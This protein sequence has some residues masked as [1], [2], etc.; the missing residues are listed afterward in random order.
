M[1]SKSIA[2]THDYRP[3]CG[4]FEIKN[5][6]IEGLG[7]FVAEGVTIPIGDVIDNHNVWRNKGGV[8]GDVTFASPVNTHVEMESDWN[9]VMFR[10]PVGGFINHSNS[11]SCAISK[12]ETGEGFN[13]Y[14]LVALRDLKAGE[15]VTVCYEQVKICSR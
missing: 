7:L 8:F 9:C 11:P 1:Y 10:T 15:E 12:V 6:E 2:D 3:L 14:K 13:F 5:S 4:L